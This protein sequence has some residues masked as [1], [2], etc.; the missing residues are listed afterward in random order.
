MPAA[1]TCVKPSGTVSQLVACASGIH[2]RYSRF[3]L[4]G[5]QEDKKSPINA[6]L[7]AQGVPNEPYTIHP[8]QSDMFFFPMEVPAT[9]LCRNDLNA[10]QQLE[11]YL[12]YK[13]HWTEHNPSCTI[14][15]KNN[16]W[17]EVLAWCFKH[18]D[19]LGGISFMPHS[20]FV[21]SQAPY[22]ELT[23]AEYA[24]KIEKMPLVDWS[25]LPEFEKEDMT[26]GS[27]ELACSA[28]A[29]EL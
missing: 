6:F 19:V 21:Y 20:D 3:I 2:T 12:T 16:E 14:Y 24:K 28:G 22:A 29:C 13:L 10:I 17:T 26:T 8:D 5:T 7:K 9:S 27:R 11:I 23:A 4:R 18:F 25:K 15:V 1:I